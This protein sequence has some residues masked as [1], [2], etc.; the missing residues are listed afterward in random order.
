VNVLV[1][2]M[3]LE[4]ISSW[5]LNDLNCFFLFWLFVELGKTVFV[6]HLIE[7]QLDTETLKTHCRNT[8]VNNVNYNYLL[9]TKI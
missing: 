9:E 6:C 3:N 2:V 5:N 1:T 8:F 7:L 4:T